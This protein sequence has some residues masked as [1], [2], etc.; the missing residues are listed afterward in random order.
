MKIR[1]R[2]ALLLLVVCG[3]VAIAGADEAPM[4]NE[5]VIS[6]TNAGLATSVILQKVDSA[7]KTKFDV[8]TNALIAL[9]GAKVDQAVIQKMILKSSGG[10][11]P[12]PAPAASGQP[13]T[14]AA[15]TAPVVKLITTSGEAT[16]A[17]IDGNINSIVAPFVGLRRFAVFSGMKSTVRIKDRHPSIVLST[18]K[19]PRQNWWFVRLDQDDDDDDRSIDVQS[20]GMWG[21]VISSAPEKDFKVDCLP[22]EAGGTT[23]KFTPKKDLK[24]GEYG[25]YYG[26]G[27]EI[28]ILYDFGIDKQ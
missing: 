13:G 26:K 9:S 6:L 17:S 28:S 12:S 27:A 19:D 1:I 16:L 20:P 22:T 24:P 23:W 14:A 2:F 10:A 15:A 7:T 3:F 25:L 4:T 18:D 5:D 8:G 21:G 11:A